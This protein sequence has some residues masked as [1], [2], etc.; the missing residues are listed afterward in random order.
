[1]M[2]VDGAAVGPGPQIQIVRHR[3]QLGLVT[4]QPR[5]AADAG[6]LR[7]WQR[8]L[9]RRLAHAT[10]QDGSGAYADGLDAA[11]VDAALAG[12]PGL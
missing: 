3:L 1:M 12:H 5:I 4:G 10:L 9:L 11:T 6:A 2:R 8:G 7:A